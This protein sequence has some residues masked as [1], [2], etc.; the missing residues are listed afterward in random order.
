[1]SRSIDIGYR[2]AD[3]GALTPVELQEPYYLLG[4]QRL[5]MEFW[6]LPQL[7]EFGLARLTTLGFT[8]PVSFVGWDDL[9]ELGREIALL[10]QHL[11]SIPFHPELLAGWLSHLVYCHSL[12]S[13][14][15]PEGCV[16]ELCIG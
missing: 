16:P 12:L 6:S 11:R 9:A 13:L 5:S 3:G 14:V 15:T 4:T 1:M 8:D 10:Q 2:S 7:R